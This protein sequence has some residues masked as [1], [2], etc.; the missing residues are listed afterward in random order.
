MGAAPPKREADF[1][2]ALREV[3]GGKAFEAWETEMPSR[4][5]PSQ[6]DRWVLGLDNQ[7]AVRLQW[8][9]KA[10]GRTE[11]DYDLQVIWEKIQGLLIKKSFVHGFPVF[12]HPITSGTEKLVKPGA[13]I[14]R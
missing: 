12:S 1:W 3:K 7:D 4:C 13:R 6:G 5:R 14:V 11:S 10:K 9:L 8:A 2:V